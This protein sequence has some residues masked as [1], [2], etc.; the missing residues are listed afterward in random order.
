MSIGQNRVLSVK[1]TFYQSKFVSMGQNPGSISQIGISI[2]QK[3]NVIGQI[4]CSISQNQL[5]SVKIEFYR[6]KYGTIG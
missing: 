1:H 2:S 6:S 3:C 4:V 5:L